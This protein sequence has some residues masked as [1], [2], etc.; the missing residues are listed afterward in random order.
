MVGI[1]KEIRN[2][3]IFI[4]IGILRKS[5]RP[6][7]ILLALLAQLMAL[8]IMHQHAGVGNVVGME[9][10]NFEV[11]SGFGRGKFSA[12]NTFHFTER[13]VKEKDFIAVL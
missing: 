11:V 6:C 5:P 10:G 1:I 4:I 3:C 13:A 8:T 2:T 9:I 7:N 12:G